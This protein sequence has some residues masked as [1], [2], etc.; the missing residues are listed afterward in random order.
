[1]LLICLQPLPLPLTPDSHPSVTEDNT[2]S[3]ILKGSE[4][5]RKNKCSRVIR[6]KVLGY[7][8]RINTSTLLTPQD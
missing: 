4:N 2:S 7:S 6:Q 3:T 1:M 5:A 8:A